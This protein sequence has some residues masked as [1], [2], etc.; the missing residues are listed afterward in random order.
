MR[1]VSLLSRIVPRMVWKHRIKTWQI[2][3]GEA[4]EQILP[5]LCSRD[6]MSIDVGAA[7]GTYCVRLLL[8]SSRVV[9]FEPNPK[10]A[11]G[12]RTQFKDTPIVSIENYALSD[13]DGSVEMRVPEDRPMWG[14][15]ESTNLLT[16]ATRLTS[17]SVQKKRLD[18]YSFQG[19]G[20]IKI[21]VEGH[22]ISVL[23]GARKTIER[24]RPKLL[25]E[26][27]Q[28]HLPEV[29]RLFSELNYSAFFLL[30][31]EQVPVEQF[32]ASI[33]QIP[34]NLVRGRRVGCY[35]NNFVFLPQ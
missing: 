11:E 28:S 29:C 19:V 27:D 35:I 17:F 16:E 18:D 21:D 12:L 8:Y 31:G 23:N 2:D 3:T 6:K 13:S 32:D 9:A 14:T 22:E 1:G 20:F 34:A 4:E 33:H 26:I 24:E 5:S 30:D 25:I 15:I 10:A 7:D